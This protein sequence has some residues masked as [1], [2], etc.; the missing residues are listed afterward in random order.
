MKRILATIL[1]SIYGLIFA[2]VF[3]GGV[4][5]ERDEFTGETTCG[6]YVSNSIYDDTGMILLR[7][8]DGSLMFAINHVVESWSSDSAFNL[9]GKTGG[10]KVYIKFSEN[11]ILTLEPIE[12]EGN[13]SDDYE[14][15]YFVTERQT[16]QRILASPNALRVRFDG[17]DG[18]EDFDI[19]HGVVL[20]L[21]QGFGQTCL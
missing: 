6:Q 1:F 11:D 18:N 13:L 17:P 20:A 12:V 14:R 10:E 9:Y 7:N 8:S 19:N 15:A 3:D 4:I 2:Q 5:N 16:L 21:A